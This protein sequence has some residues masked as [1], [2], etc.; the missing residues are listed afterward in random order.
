MEKAT[1]VKSEADM[2]LIARYG[3]ENDDDD[4]QV[5][6]SIEAVPGVG[7]DNKKS[8]AA[9]IGSDAD[10]P[11]VSNREYAMQVE[12]ERAQELRSRKVTTKKEEQQKTSDSRKQK[13][14]LKDERRKRATKGERKR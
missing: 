7:V 12:K 4:T 9:S 8:V 10:V 2:A 14:L 13:E 6:A 11:I 1:A 3:Y 5:D